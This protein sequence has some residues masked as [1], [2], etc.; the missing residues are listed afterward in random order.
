M[1]KAVDVERL[2]REYRAR[3]E[4]AKAEAAYLMLRRLNRALIADALY[5][6]YGTVEALDSAIADLQSIGLD[7]SKGLYVKADDTG[8]DLYAAAERPFLDLFTPLIVE[9]LSER[10]PPS[11]NASKLLYLL[12]ERGLAKP[13]FSHENS[14]LREYYRVLYGE[15]LD[16]QAFKA[17]VRE[18]EGYW[19]VEFTDGYRSFYPQYLS[20]IVPRLRQLAARVR[21]HVEP[22]EA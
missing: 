7:L 6:R 19:V 16:E 13:G 17:L 3:G 4:L 1:V 22:P 2:F 12:V 5:A 8:E 10:R 15:E 11:L 9:K 18:L 14:R 21:V 20:A